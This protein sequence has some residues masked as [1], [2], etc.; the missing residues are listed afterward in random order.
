LAFPT[1]VVLVS[2][3]SNCF[4]IEI[5]R[6][7]DIGRFSIS[8]FVIGR[9]TMDQAVQDFVNSKRI[10]VVG[11]SRKGNKFGNTIATELKGRGYQVSIVHP[12]AQEI[13]GERCY[14][15]LAALQG[16]VDAVLVCVPPKAA[17]QV[18]QEAVDAGIKNIWLQQGAQ[19]PES[20]TLAKKLGVTPV[21]GKCVL[22]YA[23]P[24]QSIHRFH[25]FIAKLIRQY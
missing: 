4:I 23:E 16:K 9:A 25:R 15:N 1:N 11:V 17:G 8:Q 3:H 20:I 7:N 5:D 21:E 24:V 10:A 14:P 22:M 19:S 18:V 13:G 6:I 12:E 2:T